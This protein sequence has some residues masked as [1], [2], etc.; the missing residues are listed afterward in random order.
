MLSGQA[1]DTALSLLPTS[2]LVGVAFR[3]ISVQYAS[4]ALSAIGSLKRGGRYN[5][6]NEFEV[7]YI[8]ESQV[9]ALQE[10][11]S[12]VQTSQGLISLRAQSRTILTIDYRLNAVLD[13]TNSLIQDALG[14][15]FQELTG[16]WIPTSV[17]GKISPTQQLGAAAHRLAKIDALKYPSAKDPGSYNLAVFVSK[18]S[19]SSSLEVYDSSGTINARLP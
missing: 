5:T 7:L 17:Q 14:T 8:S 12:I 6:A 19:T 9:T 13:L 18:L 10:V 15:S 3:A 16:L 11:G 2:P 4:S 1:L